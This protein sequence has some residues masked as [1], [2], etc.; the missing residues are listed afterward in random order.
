[1]DEGE[2]KAELTVILPLR[3]EETGQA[4]TAEKKGAEK[5][6]TS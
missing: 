3:V 2:Y 5:A 4:A 6:K 1:M